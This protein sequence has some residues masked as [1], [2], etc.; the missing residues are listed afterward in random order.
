LLAQLLCQL[1]T[2]LAQP[3]FLLGACLLVFSNP[4]FFYPIENNAEQSYFLSRFAK[5][6]GVTLCGFSK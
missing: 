4:T 6:N 3:A 2:W 1:S 5:N